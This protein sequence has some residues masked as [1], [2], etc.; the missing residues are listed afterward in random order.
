[1]NRTKLEMWH[2]NV[3]DKELNPTLHELHYMS[4]AW[5]GLSVTMATYSVASWVMLLKVYGAS[6]LMLL[7]L[8]S[9]RGNNNTVNAHKHTHRTY[10]MQQRRQTVQA[11]DI[12][13]LFSRLHERHIH[14]WQLLQSCQLLGHRCQHIT[15]QVSARKH[16]ADLGCCTDKKNWIFRGWINAT[17]THC[18]LT[19]SQ[20]E[21]RG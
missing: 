21:N 16:I 8:R 14:Q 15:L 7:L 9:L 3:W 19:V 10:C 6:V 11:N 13:V 2:I 18:G 4:F 12:W 20:N 1:M 5:P 17:I